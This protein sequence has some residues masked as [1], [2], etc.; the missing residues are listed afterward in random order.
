M[1]TRVSMRASDPPG[2]LWTPRPKARCSRAFSRSTRNSAGSSKWL[3]SRFAAPLTTI[4]WRR[5]EC[6]RRPWRSSGGPAGS[7]P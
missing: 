3:G 2:Q 4:R 6:R 1:L 5:R 7:H